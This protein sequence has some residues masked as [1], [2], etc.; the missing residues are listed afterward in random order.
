MQIK[1]KELPGT[2]GAT[3]RR[4]PASRVAASLSL[5]WVVASGCA[6][7]RVEKSVTATA[8]GNDPNQQIE[9][10]HRLADAPVTSYDDAFHAVLLFAGGDDP[11]PDYAGRLKAMKD[12][13]LLAG[14]FARSA[15][16]AVDRGTLSVAL[17]KTLKIKGGVVMSL[18]GP[19]A[20]YATKELEFI[21]V[22]PASSPNQTFSGSEFLAV[23]SRAEEYQKT[24]DVAATA[25]G[26]A[27]YTPP[28]LQVRNAGPN[29]RPATQRVTEPE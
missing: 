17:V 26:G 14:N 23:M 19:S 6:S 12:R 4:L 3:F 2:R 22:Y 8:G 15:D 10:W 16:E 29:P 9:F 1:K 13:G 20:R 25:G 7:A 11:A 18:F 24:N 5:L 28:E 21:E 27:G